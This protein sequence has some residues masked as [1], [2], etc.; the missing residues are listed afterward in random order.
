MDRCILRWALAW[1]LVAWCLLGCARGGDGG[2]GF[3]GFGG[4][5]GDGGHGGHKKGGGN[6]GL[7]EL[8]LA[9]VLASVLQR[10]GHHHSHPIPI[11]IPVPHH[12]R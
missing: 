4:G 10:K 2:G 1:L 8:L 7:P 5:G 3:G 12:G 6:N 9:G 11:F